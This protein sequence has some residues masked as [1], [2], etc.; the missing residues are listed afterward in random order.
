MSISTKI[1]NLSTVAA[2][3]AFGVVLSTGICQQ[4][5]A[6]DTLQPSQELQAGGQSIAS[7]NQRYFLSLQADGNLV[8][9]DNAARR[10]LWASNT[11]GVAVAKATM[12]ADGNLVMRG[13]NSKAIWATNTENNNGARL[14]LQDDGNLVIYTSRNRVLW[15][16]HTRPLE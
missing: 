8:L 13:Y 11:S 4:A 10:V 1:I 16:T 15:A 6:N 9:T 7:R 3:A 2:L 14:E 5:Q 12:Q